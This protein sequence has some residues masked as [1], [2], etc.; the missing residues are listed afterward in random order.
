MAC[1][2]ESEAKCVQQST[3]IEH[4]RKEWRVKMELM[5]NNTYTFIA[6]LYKDDFQ[7]A[8][9]TDEIDRREVAS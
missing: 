4:M 7:I 8:N 5:G 6:F 3:G 9:L 1:L 2:L